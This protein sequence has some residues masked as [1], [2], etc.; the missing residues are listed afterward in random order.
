MA[1]ISGVLLSGALL[2]LDARS[3]LAFD[4]ILLFALCVVAGV[5][6][7]RGALIAGALFKILPALFNDLGLSADITLIIFGAA[8]LHAITTAPRG[9]AGQLEALFKRKAAAQ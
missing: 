1:G 3:F 5:H 9:I 8:L 7:W 4:G 6:S 2:Q